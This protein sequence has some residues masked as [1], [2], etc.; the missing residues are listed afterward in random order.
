M[1][2]AGLVDDGVA[3]DLARVAA[4]VVGRG[5][6]DV[7]RPRAVVVVRGAEARDPRHHLLLDGHD[8]LPLLVDPRH[9][10]IMI[11]FL[12]SQH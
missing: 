10:L 4:G 6:A 11:S 2:V 8:H 1:D 12:Q 9:L 7:H 3:V 5:A